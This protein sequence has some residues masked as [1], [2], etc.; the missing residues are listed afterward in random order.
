MVAPSGYRA[1]HV[2][3]VRDGRRIEIQLRTPRE[4]E[5]AVAVERTGTRLGIPLKEGLGPADLRDYFRLA[6]HGMYL[7]GRGE[8]PDPAFL[9]EF[10]ASR[11]AV[12]HYFSQVT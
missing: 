10:N 11:D 9:A 7:E 12:R 6:S 8:T 3:A 5:W 2:L 4:H 1:V